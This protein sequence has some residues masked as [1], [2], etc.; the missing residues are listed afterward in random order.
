MAIMDSISGEMRA[1]LERSAR[2]VR[3]HSAIRLISHYDA[4]GIS[5]AAIVR[6]ALRRLGKELDMTIFHT[7]SVNEIGI[8][9]GIDA[10]CVVMTDMGTSYL[11]RLSDKGWDI[12]ILD[13]HRIPADTEIPER[14]GFAF[15]NPLS[16]GID[17]SRNACGASM[18][19]LFALAL[20]ENN[21]D[22]VPLAL[23]G[24]FGDKQHLGGFQSINKCIV[25]SAVEN[26]TIERIPNLA[27]PSGMT[28]YQAIMS[29]P[30]PYLINT[31]GQADR[32]TRFVKSCELKMTDSPNSVAQGAIDRFAEELAARMRR[33]GVTEE[34][35]K[36][37][38]GDRYYSPRYGL[39]V[40]ELSSILDGCGRRDAYASA[41]E[42]CDTLDFTFASVKSQEFSEKLIKAIEPAFRNMVTMENIQYF[43]IREKGLAGGIASAIVRYLGNPEKPV[44][45]ITLTEEGRTDLSSRGTMHMIERGLDLSS[46]MNTVCAEMGGQGGG[47]VIAAGGT[48]PPG[49]EG[50]FVRRID[51][52]IGDQ[53]SK[54]EPV[55]FIAYSIQ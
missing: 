42:A 52:F 22:L 44:I 49:T 30:E 23:S 28:F 14:E 7:L 9:E 2:I 47:H 39:D 51:S 33:N 13:H 3:G 16:Y 54:N 10:E 36:E 29:C 5:A 48:I 24:M 37:T 31:T 21:T 17:G 25:D 18:A 50:E 45:G 19:Y 38:F 53:F 43:V 27:Y 15:V 6:E 41:L 35:I 26:G 4:D 8:T 34:I 1:E 55:R 46:A 20:D 11:Q 40:S 32:V 12:V